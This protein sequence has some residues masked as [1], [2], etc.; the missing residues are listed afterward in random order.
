M[1]AKDIPLKDLILD[2]NNYRLQ[3]A[4]GFVLFADDR[5]HLEQVQSTTLQR[6]QKEAIKDLRSSILANGFLP[7]E[8]I[9]VTPYKYAD[10]L[11]LVIEGNRRV[12]A[13]KSIEDQAAAGI[14]I[15][16][17]V[18]E[19]LKAV[20][21]I[22]AADEASFPYF[23]ETLMGIRHVGGIRQWGG[24]QRAK[25]IADL[26]DVH[27]VDASA[28]SERLGLA[29]Q[30]VNRR[31]RAF[32]ALQ[33]M[34]DNEEFGEYATPAL[35][36]IFHEAISLPGVRSWLGWNATT[37]AFEND[38]DVENFYRLITPR[39]SSDGA[40]DK[41]AKISGYADVRELKHIIGNAEA[42]ST[43]FDPDKS[44]LDALSIARKDEM[45]KKWRS[46]VSEARVAL[47]KISA[48]EVS[49]F[50]DDDV[51]LIQSIIDTGVEVL[52]IHKSIKA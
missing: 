47:Q 12:A 26:R 5:F 23:K 51:A 1:E 32:K 49:K 28:V 42:Q 40:D 52:G 22:V 6:L 8:R 35:Y 13:L 46:E 44:L 7:I 18:L 33:Q 19:T 15:P 38:E 48:I 34:Q 16:A 43:L 39:S 14:D 30:E 9:V 17:K 20:P 41:P 11:Y 50:S 25:L 31:Y 45:T 27:D 24:Y 37:A 2:P 3:E 4:S 29:I 36:P 10:G 21:C